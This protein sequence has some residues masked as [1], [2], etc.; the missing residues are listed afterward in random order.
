[1]STSRLPPSLQRTVRLQF[2]LK[3]MFAVVTLAALVAATVRRVEDAGEFIGLMSWVLGPIILVVTIIAAI[4]WWQL[5]PRAAVSSAAFLLCGLVDAV[6]GNQQYGR[7]ERHSRDTRQY[8]VA[9]GRG[10]VRARACRWRGRPGFSLRPLPSWSLAA[11]GIFTRWHEV[12][13]AIIRYLADGP[14]GQPVKPEMID[15]DMPLL[16]LSLLAL[17]T[18]F[19]A[20]VGWGMSVASTVIH[21]RRVSAHASARHVARL[22]VLP[23]R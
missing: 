1:M 21:A 20:L 4:S 12:R 11:L 13:S 18:V 15:A 10:W 5:G 14:P 2:S 19:G 9:G 6:C 3:L 8:A 22:S 23:V 16:W 17:S 7:T